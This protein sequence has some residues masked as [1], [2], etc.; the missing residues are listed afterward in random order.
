MQQVVVYELRSVH[1][2]NAAIGRTQNFEDQLE[3]DGMYVPL[4]VRAALYNGI[5]NGDTVRDFAPVCSTGNCTWT[6]ISSLAICSACKNVDPNIAVSCNT[7]VTWGPYNYGHEN[8]SCSYKSPNNFAGF[9]ASSLYMDGGFYTFSV[10]AVTSANTAA[11]LQNPSNNQ[12]AGLRSPWA[13]FAKATI[14]NNATM[15]MN[16]NVTNITI[17]PVTPC[18][19]TYNVSVYEGTPTSK[20]VNTWQFESWTYN[21]TTNQIDFARPP[22][23]VVKGTTNTAFTIDGNTG[24]GFVNL[25][26]QAFNGT[27]T[28]PET[29][30]DTPKSYSSDTMQ[31][32]YMIDDLGQMMEN[33]ASSLS[34][35]MRTVSSAVVH[36]KVWA[37]KS[38]VHVRWIWLL[39]PMALMPASLAFLSTAIWTSRS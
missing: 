28:L 33:V 3:V 36:G 8:L 12:I 10:L 1:T 19:K 22:V 31:A 39:L 16:L 7:S 20:V 11:V 30:A 27:A 5:W 2:A 15:G 37:M 29:D 26:Q 32:L 17:C 35:Y 13:A 9:N 21:G 25:L 38:Y 6:P 34:S 24:L 23:D 14:N 18:L 4:K